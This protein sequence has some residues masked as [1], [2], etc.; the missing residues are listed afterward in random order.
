MVG[1]GIDLV[2]I[3]RFESSLRRNDFIKRCFSQSEIHYYNKTKKA[4]FLAGRFAAKEALVKAL[5]TG[6]IEGIS[7]SDIEIVKLP[8]GAPQIKLKDSVANLADNLGIKR[9]LISISHTKTM[10]TAIVIAL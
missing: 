8:S 2:D 3:K 10:A 1:I 5:G 4:A 6:L 9:W 7:F